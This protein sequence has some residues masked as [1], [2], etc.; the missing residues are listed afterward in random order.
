MDM[1]NHD[2]PRQGFTLVEL[3]VVIGIIGIL[4]S[5]L[6]PALGRGIARAKSVACLSQLRQMA[7][8]RYSRWVCPAENDSTV[9]MSYFSSHGELQRHAIRDPQTITAGDRNVM[10]I[11]NG[12]IPSPL[13]GIVRLF[14]TN[15]FG[16]GTKM[17]RGNGNLLLGDGSAHRTDGRKLN[18]MI[19]L[20]PDP[21]F[22]WDIPDGE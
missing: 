11:Q 13:T 1:R 5:L 19:G 3:L 20:Q 12:G 15:S 2:L 16:W 18:A 9:T 7:Q 6:L 4:A 14:R 8:G 10:L 21:V 17:H 22:D